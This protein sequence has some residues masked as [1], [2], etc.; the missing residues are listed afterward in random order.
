MATAETATNVA[1]KIFFNVMC[2]NPPSF[3]ETTKPTTP[4][5]AVQH[6]GIWVTRYQHGCIIQVSWEELSDFIENNGGTPA[7]P[8]P[9]WVLALPGSNYKVS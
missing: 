6:L 5:A 7:A 2:E 4:L 3:R 8:L 9:V 1:N